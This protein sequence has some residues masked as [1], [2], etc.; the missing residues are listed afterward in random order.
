VQSRACFLAPETPI[1][2]RQQTC[3]FTSDNNQNKPPTSRNS[4]TNALRRGVLPYKPVAYDYSV[5]HTKQ[6]PSAAM[7]S[8]ESAFDVGASSDFEPEPLPK[9]VSSKFSFSSVQEIC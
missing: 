1:T 8:D 4:A 6:T 3:A 9:A 7:S 2:E 5:P